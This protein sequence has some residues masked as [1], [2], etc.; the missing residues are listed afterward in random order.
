[1]VFVVVVVFLRSGSLVPVT[2]ELQALGV[3]CSEV[4][5]SG[6]GYPLGDFEMIRQTMAN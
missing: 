5:G 2:L 6:S 1:M 3:R 4:K